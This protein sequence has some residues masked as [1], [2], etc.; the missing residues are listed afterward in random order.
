[1][2]R[3]SSTS[4][5]STGIGDRDLLIGLLRVD[6]VVRDRQRL[7][8]LVLADLRAS[9]APAADQLVNGLFRDDLVGRARH[10][11]DSSRGWL[12]EACCF[13]HMVAKPIDLRQRVTRKARI[14]LRRAREALLQPRIPPREEVRH[15]EECAGEAPRPKEGDSPRSERRRNQHRLIEV[16]PPGGEPCGCDCCR[17]K[18]DDRRAIPQTVREI[19]RALRACGHLLGC[20]FREHGGHSVGVPVPWDAREV[21]VEASFVEE[22]R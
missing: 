14:A 18:A 6:H 20:E 11:R 19:E 21:H 12:C 4:L 5:K 7:G 22:D 17:G 1:M 2:S 16:R 10:D 8:E 9:G 15:G 3:D 13:E